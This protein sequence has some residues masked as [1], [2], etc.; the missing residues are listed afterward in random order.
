MRLWGIRKVF[1]AL[2]LQ[3]LTHSRHNRPRF[4]DFSNCVFSYWS[5]API[6]HKNFVFVWRVSAPG[7][8]T[9]PG[10]NPS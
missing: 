7:A 8:L 2:C 4:Y 5:C 9:H 1:V 6:F 3:T 10:S